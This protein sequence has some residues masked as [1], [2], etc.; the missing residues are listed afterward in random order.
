M[1]NTC[2]DRRGEIVPRLPNY[3]FQKNLDS[4]FLENSEEHQIEVLSL[5]SCYF[6]PYQI[7]DGPT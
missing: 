2:D 6:L 1:H 3:L 7:C 5:L 4:V